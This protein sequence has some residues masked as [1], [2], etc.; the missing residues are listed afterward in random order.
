MTAITVTT[1]PP[2]N[3]KPISDSVMVPSP[4]SA[5]RSARVVV[6][7]LAHVV[8]RARTRGERSVGVVDALGERVLRGDLGHHVLRVPLERGQHVV[9]ERPDA[10]AVLLDQALQR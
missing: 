3:S 6:G 2:K 10:H 8:V 9:R 1:T 5:R 4:S 7:E